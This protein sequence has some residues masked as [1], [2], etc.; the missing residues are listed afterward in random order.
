[1]VG[2]EQGCSQELVGN[3]LGKPQDDF[4]STELPSAL[5]CRRETHKWRSWDCHQAASLRLDAKMPFALGS[6]LEY[7]EIKGTSAAVSLGACCTRAG[8]QE[9]AAE[10]DGAG[11]STTCLVLALPG[12]MSPVLLPGWWCLASAGHFWGETTVWV[13]QSL[14]RGG[15]ECSCPPACFFPP[16]NR[17]H[18]PSRRG[19]GG[20]DVFW[21]KILGFCWAEGM[22]SEHLRLPECY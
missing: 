9:G 16:Q 17:V 15:R 13:K 2:S 8:G 6:S 22:G 20:F 4:G 18:P 12:G 1:M 7:T 3:P 5:R 10:G 11:C 21:E 14:R 19:F